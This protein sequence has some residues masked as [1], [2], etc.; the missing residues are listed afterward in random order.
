MYNGEGRNSKEVFLNPEFEG[1][2]VD[3]KTMTALE[4]EDLYEL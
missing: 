2:V 4:D 1:H 3:S